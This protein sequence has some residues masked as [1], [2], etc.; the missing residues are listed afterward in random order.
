MGGFGKVFLGIVVVA[1]IV[2]GAYYAYTNWWGSE[3]ANKAVGSVKG[4]AVR[5][6][7]TTKE[8]IS[9]AQA[10][11]G[12]RI[13][14]FI[15]EKTGLA[16]SSIGDAISNFGGS[17]IGETMDASPQTIPNTTSFP[18][19]S[20][21]SG[22][23]NS[24]TTLAATGSNFVLP[25]PFTAIMT[26]V[27]VPL[28]FS[29]NRDVDYTI[30]WADGTTEK[31]KVPGGKSALISH[32]WKRSGDYTVTFVISDTKESRTYSFPVRVY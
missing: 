18:Q 26:M 27:N 20:I 24:T 11:T 16:I 13:G 10:T 23:V 30:D 21:L 29:I 19:S 6:V 3:D 2:Y 9:D 32:E 17:I 22:G 1:L 4:I 31:G 15:K 25:P 5:A 14:M 28:A 7:Q 12:E 8:K